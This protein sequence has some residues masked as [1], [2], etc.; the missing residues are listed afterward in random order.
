MSFAGLSMHTS[1]ELLRDKGIIGAEE[2]GGDASKRVDDL[3]DLFAAM[4]ASDS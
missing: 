1:K 2:Y 4:H 3:A